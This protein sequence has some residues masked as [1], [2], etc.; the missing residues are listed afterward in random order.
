MLGTLGT[1]YLVA[2]R[3]V[4]EV[5]LAKWPVGLEMGKDYELVE[6]KLDGGIDL[7]TWALGH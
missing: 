4:D 7:G 5:V 2:Q 6:V 3:H 1:G